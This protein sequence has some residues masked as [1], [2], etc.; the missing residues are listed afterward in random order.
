MPVRRVRG[1]V[2]R[3][4]SSLVVLSAVVLAGVVVP[5]GAAGSPGVATGDATLLGKGPGGV[6]GNGDAEEPAVSPDGRWVAFDSTSTNLV[7]GFVDNNTTGNDVYLL[8]RST[9]AVSLVSHATTGA[10]QGSNKDSEEA[11]VS[12]DGRWVGFRS[13]ATNLVTGATVTGTYNNVYLWD[14]TTGAITL[15]S[16][17]V[18]TATAEAN[19]SS[20]TGQNIVDG[21]ISGDG[22]YLSFRSSATNLITGFVAGIIGGSNAY[23]YDRV[24][25]ASTLVS[26]SLGNPLKGANQ[27]I[28]DVVSSGD[29]ST[30]GFTTAATDLVS[31][32]VAG[33]AGATNAYVA[34]RAT[35]TP[36]LVSKAVGTSSTGGNDSTRVASLSGDGRVVAVNSR[37]TNL[38][39]GFVD[40]NAADFDVFGYDLVA[41]TVALVSHSTASLVDGGN[42]G[43]YE[44]RLGT[45]GRYVAFSSMA[46]DL[47]TGFVNGNAA[48]NDIFVF[49][50]ASGAT[51]LVSHV[52]GSATAGGNQGSYEPAVAQGAASVVF[53][54]AATDLVSGD[55][56]AKVDLFAVAPLAGYRFVASDGGIFSFGPAAGFFGSTGAI[57]LNQPIVGMAATASGQGYWLVA[58][59][60]GIFAFGDAVF[61]GSTGAI[62]LNQPIVGMARSFTGAGYWLVASDGGIFG[63]GDAVFHGS[64]GAVHLNQPIVG[65][66]ATPTGRGYWLVARDGGIFA[67][68]D[69]GFFGSTGAIHLNQP[70]VGMAASRSGFGYWLVAS[71]GGIF[72]F[73][74]AVFLGS[75][76]AIH[77]NQPIVGMSGTW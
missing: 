40:H 71:D 21:S 62:H 23:V 3:W 77:L 26:H 13:L 18:G 47:V 64:T 35:A 43:S 68:G 66:A 10:T 37:A 38:M 51:S 31:G 19:A 34:D 49:D 41:G 16:H 76:G 29:G 8:D 25:N 57:H 14:R 73:G 50:R 39:T 59:D 63:F 48:G 55:T 5:A 24:A 36:V 2:P 52:P 61:H 15:A 46:T 75:T 56:N 4:I 20:V 69:A 60:G 72:A 6:L 22:R 65:M 1:R 67:F 28:G 32:F 27:T 11:T 54:S 42:A 74:D 12:D 17:A 44:G 70:I 7:S 45:D 30:I 33:G 9:G 58:R 53:A